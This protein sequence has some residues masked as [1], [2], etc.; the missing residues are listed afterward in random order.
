M[1]GEILCYKPTC[2]QHKLHHGTETFLSTAGR[3]CL[4][5]SELSSLPLY[6]I[7][8]YKIPKTV[9]RKIFAILRIFLW[10]GLHDKKKMCKVAREKCILE[11]SSPFFTLIDIAYAV[12]FHFTFQLYNVFGAGNFV[13]TW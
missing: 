3:L 7:F 12:Y 8:F 1:S 13:K 10:S 5:K 9:A 2:K 6:Y 11:K 4:I